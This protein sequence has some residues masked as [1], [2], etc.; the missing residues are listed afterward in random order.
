[1]NCCMRARPS[2]QLYLLHIL[3][4]MQALAIAWG[5]QGTMDADNVRG[6]IDCD[7]GSSNRCAIGSSLGRTGPG[8]YSVHIADFLICQLS[9]S[10]QAEPRYQLPCADLR[11]VGAHLVAVMR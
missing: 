7:H 6:N 8:V 4:Q 9:D 1:M 11:H 3:P 2:P 10:P 5:V